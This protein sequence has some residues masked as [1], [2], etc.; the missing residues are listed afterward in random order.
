MILMTAFPDGQVI[1][2]LSFSIGDWYF[3]LKNR[4]Y[5][6]STV[7]FKVLLPTLSGLS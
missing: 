4:I 2:A 3:P 7:L 1:I 5:L 6:S